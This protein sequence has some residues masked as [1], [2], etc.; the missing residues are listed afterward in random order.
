M[1]PAS[2]IAIGS[3]TGFLLLLLAVACRATPT[4]TPPEA[5]TEALADV[6]SVRTTGEP[7][8]YRFDVGIRSPDQGCEQYADWWE[9]VSEDGRLIHR[10][11]LA[12]SHVA[13]QPFVRSGEPVLVEPETVVW[14]RAHMHPAGYGGAAFRG[15]VSGGLAAADLP[16]SFAADLA[17]QPPR[18][19]DCAH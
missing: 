1:N 5:L 11:V 18:P 13:E 14:V 8:A 9:V 15:S 7:G 4:E 6:V 2:R 16:A 3:L 17:G 12:H 19:P 10:R